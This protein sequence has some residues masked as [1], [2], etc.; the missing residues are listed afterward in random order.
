MITVAKN[1]LFEMHFIFVQ[2]SS[3][4]TKYFAFHLLYQWEKNPKCIVF[5]S[6]SWNFRQTKSVF[7]DS[8][9]TVCSNYCCSLNW[10][11][12]F[13]VY[14][15]IDCLNPV[16]FQ[17]ACRISFSFLSLSSL[18]SSFFYFF[19]LFFVFVGVLRNVALVVVCFFVK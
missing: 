4:H 17:Y 6:K 10:F 18:S 8:F 3:I 16:N 12:F 15:F 5:A 1:T 11:L 14:E 2:I 13:S 9:R 19:C 7:K